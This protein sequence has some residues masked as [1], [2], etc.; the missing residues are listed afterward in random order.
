MPL[1]RL[2][3]WLVLAL[4]AS[5]T[6]MVIGTAHDQKALTSFAATAFAGVILSTAVAVNLPM[7][8]GE[9]P[10][11]DTNPAFASGLRNIRL[12]MLVYAWGGLALFAMYR[13]SD[14]RWFHAPQY[15]A[16]ATLI[17]GGLLMYVNRLC[18]TEP[19]RAPPAFLNIAHGLTAAGGLA[20]LIGS[21][22]VWSQRADWAAN[23]VFLWGGIAMVGLCLIAAIT[24]ARMAR[25]TPA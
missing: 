13:L 2:M 9:S 23:T 18:N 20:F 14:L 16:G 17:A 22:K 6:F 15:A 24:Q 19:R 8:R 10:F 7:W 21:G 12:A 3:P 25:T 5:V 4:A 11:G 1:S